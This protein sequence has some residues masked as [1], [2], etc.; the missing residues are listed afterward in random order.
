MGMSYKN[1][2]PTFILL[3]IKVGGLFKLLPQNLH[4]LSPSKPLALNFKIQISLKH[5]FNNL[6]S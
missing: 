1:N 2:P 6:R 4:N 5:S 3:T